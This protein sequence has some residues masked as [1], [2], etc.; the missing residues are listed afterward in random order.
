MLVAHREHR[1]LERA[2]LHFGEEGGKFLLGSQIEASRTRMSE[3]ASAMEPRG[4]A[5]VGT[6]A[7]L[8]IPRR[9][10]RGA[11]GLWPAGLSG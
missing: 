10:I 7:C 1:L 4:A 8:G 5:A 3:T 2:S 6:V 11:G 9:I